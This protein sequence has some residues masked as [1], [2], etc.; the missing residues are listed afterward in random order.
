M[1]SNFIF[2]DTLHI[3]C[4]VIVVY[5]YHW[6]RR[7][8]KKDKIKPL[9]NLWGVITVSCKSYYI[10]TEIPPFISTVHS[11]VTGSRIVIFALGICII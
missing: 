5:I 6:E 4:T 9:K 10:R 11:C 3:I 1:F 2:L 8:T 7:K